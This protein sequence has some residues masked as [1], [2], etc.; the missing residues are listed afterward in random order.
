MGTE[1]VRGDPRRTK[2]IDNPE[3][4]YTNPY[5]I[6]DCDITEWEARCWLLS[7][8]ERAGSGSVV[9]DNNIARWRRGTGMPAVSEERRCETCRKIFTPL[10]STATYCSPACRVR[11]SRR[12][13]LT[14]KPIPE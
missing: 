14:R 10:R 8:G 11:A 13:T 1:W 2:I 6:P 12:V 5:G 4:P 3:P 9:Y 7:Q